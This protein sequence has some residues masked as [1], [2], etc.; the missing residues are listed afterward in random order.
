MRTTLRFSTLIIILLFTMFT[1]TSMAN[2]PKFKTPDFAYPQ[3]V[4]KDAQAL[5]KKSEAMPASLDADITRTRA[6]IELCV[7]QQ[8]I[9]FDTTFTQ[10]AFIEAQLANS[11]L[12]DVGRALL[13]AYEAKLFTDIYRRNSWK[14]N[15]VDAP[16]QPYPADVSEWS[17]LQF[18]THISELLEKA[19]SYAG[20]TPLSD[21]SAV[22]EASPEGLL[23]IPTLADFVRKLTYDTY[24]SF[25]YSD[26]SFS[27]KAKSV[28]ADAI[29][30][31]AADSAPWFYWSVEQFGGPRGTAP[32]YER[33]SEL[34]SQH[35]SA[36]AARYVLQQM[37]RHY[38]PTNIS[39]EAN[40]L[41]IRQKERERR[42][43]FLI[44][45]I[46]NS[47]KA[48]PKWYGN[49]SLK[50]SLN[51]LTQPEASFS[52]PSKAGVGEKTAIDITYA[53]AKKVQLGIYSL[54]AGTTRTDAKAI[55]R[56]MPKVFSAELTP[57]DT[58]GK[59]TEY[60]S[61]DKPGL[62]AVIISINGTT[63][64]GYVRNLLVTPL[65]GFVVNG[66]P[67]SA[68]IVGDYTLG[69]PLKGTQASLVTNN[70]RSNTNT[71]PRRLG[72]T[73]SDGVLVFDTPKSENR[74]ISRYISLSYQGVTYDLNKKLDV[75]PYAPVEESDSYD[76]Q[77]MTDR[78]I[79]HPGDSIS[80]AAVLGMKKK[81][82]TEGTVLSGKDVTVKLFDANYKLVDTISV[83]T[84]SNGRVYGTFATK[85]GGLTGDYT[86]QVVNKD[87]SRTTT[88]MVSDFKAPTIEAEIKSVR[89]D[90]PAPGAV[91][92][93]GVAKTY[94]GM[95]VAGADVAV[96]L[97]GASRWR[98]FRPQTTLTTMNVTTTAD[99][100]FSVVFPAD[101]LA[102]PFNNGIP[103]TDFVAQFTVTS[104]TAETAETSKSFTTGKP[105]SLDIITPSLANS[106]KP[107]DM[108]IRAYDANGN[109]KP[110]A[111][112][113]QLCDDAKTPGLPSGTVTA[114]TPVKLDFS[115]L[116]SG[117]YFFMA[118][119]V[120]TTLAD[121]APKDEIRLYSLHRN[122]LPASVKGFILPESKTKVKNG[123]AEVL[124]GTNADRLYL[125]TITAKKD[126]LD[127][128]RLHELRKGFSKVKVKVDKDVSKAQL[129][130]AAIL[131]GEV[132]NQTVT[133]EADKAETTEIIAESF[134]D[135][136]VPGRGETW[137][138]RL[139]KG[140]KT[141]TDAAMV[142]TM[143][144]HALDALTDGDWP[145]IGFKFWQPNSRM[146]LSSPSFYTISGNVSVR[147]NY[148]EEK[149]I[150]WP[151]F[152]FADGPR[153]LYI[154]GSRMML[155]SAATNSAVEDY[156]EEDVECEATGAIEEAYAA[157]EAG[158]EVP[159]PNYCTIDQSKSGPKMLDVEYREAEVLQA[160]WKPALVA[161]K[162]GNIDIVFTVPNA[163]TTWRFKAFAWD[164]KLN[165]ADYIESALANK[166]VMV[167]ANLPR[168]LRQGDTATILA[169]VFNNS[170]ETSAVTTT[171]EIF[172]I[173]SGKTVST[174]SFT[175]TIAPLAS[176]IVK[177]DATAP[178][179]AA[180]I[181][182]RVRAVAGSFAD[183]E[184][185]AI[186]VLASATTVIESTEFYL[187]PDDSKPFEL[188]V[189]GKDSELTLQ[190]CQ[191]P[192]WTIVRAMRGIA[193][194]ESLTATGTVS[195]LFSAL[196]AKHITD[197]NPAIA[198]AIRRWNGNPSDRALTSM[199]ER[200]ETLKKLLLD[201]T[202]WVQT[203][204]SNT[205]RME[206]LAS[207]LEPGQSAKAIADARTALAKFQNA[208]GG[209]CWGGWSHESSVWSTEIV[210]TTLGIANSLGMLGSDYDSL[211]EPAFEYLQKEAAKPR[212]P[213]TDEDLA[214]IATFFPGYKQTVGGSRIIR[215]TVAAIARNWKSDNT[216]AKAYDVL[217]LAGNG[218][219][220]EAA[221]VLESIRQ[222]GVVRP[223]MGLCFPNVSDT[224]SYATI[225]QAFAKMDASKTEIDAMRQWLTVQAQ[226]LD[227]IGA[228]NPDYIIA[229]VMMTGSDWTSVPVAQNVTVNG[230][231]LQIDDIES[232]TGYF[233]QTIDA[234]G[235]VTITVRPNGVTPSYGSVI[236][237]SRRPM[238]AVKARPGRDLSIE[239]RCL[240]ERDGQWVETDRFTLGERVRV[241]LTVKAK[242]NLEYV[243]IDDERPAAFAPV[244]QLPGYVW[245]GGLGFY[246]ENLD[247]ST[248]L[249]ISYLP[250]GTYHLSYD[251]T[252]AAAGT[253]IS[254]IATLQSQ[255]APELT[256]HSAGSPITVE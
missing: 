227:D 203:A 83:T 103:Y 175:D 239:K 173:E 236:A 235:K 222:F 251:M 82:K 210:L 89:R 245:D 25:I 16:L 114:G 9:D 7:A 47:L 125:Y 131:D 27:D 243:S 208:D 5:L 147:F 128:V 241:Q 224:R 67:K 137:R 172:D 189:N 182:Y 161:D 107:F 79:Y 249:F 65:Y 98:W 231:P 61:I 100:T 14:Y 52:M 180:A 242:R 199:L 174:Q 68:V 19:A 250:Q 201:Q 206:A 33:L 42:A 73:D 49:N 211:L 66:G 29:K 252:A 40:D 20:G 215:N 152:I 23:Y 171:V 209:F 28:C 188:T 234:T 238:K 69:S 240:V 184:Q 214:L 96:T 18:R 102:K 162:D 223:G 75:N 190:Y 221:K 194:T 123:A 44:A 198:D 93:E 117:D 155:K 122:T 37:C 160:F 70:Y 2:G 254:G 256:A 59:A 116:T 183:G 205:A 12:T 32:E 3:T 143:Y 106:D 192:I 48:F 124:I 193:S 195:H 39:Y 141:I 87:R 168:F 92:L 78:A 186:P 187:N 4:I 94:S 34:Y 218:R 200:N 101:I 26:N 77:I 166:P 225:I 151:E 127:A 30:T 170:D 119:P 46:S 64:G 202:P 153:P 15:R 133:L 136:L 111:V 140:G 179:S 76:I 156:K 253:F 81:G 24:S 185:A 212:M 105:Y 142:A 132:Y 230:T 41:E 113:W 163:N 167:Q 11:K 126:T 220:A 1:N 217:I 80:W 129:I 10:P 60:F 74:Y 237:I 45:E 104:L 51:K 8:A 56:R 135:K 196:A 204:K 58:R 177:I 85:K 120:D 55:A 108:T 165:A 118:E 71:T 159:R 72:K 255:Y 207:L 158:S 229:A 228:Y 97:L 233:A 121:A 145:F 144:N 164:K 84:D 139:A 86:I 176:A 246:R 63:D 115:N 244:D 109:E 21:L 62:Y 157:D 90:V 154:R 50:N 54:P 213:E 17:G 150:I 53:F 138:F 219:R 146:T 38:T 6:V 31:S 95:P 130:V 178:V 112:K 148:L 248:R 226:A 36:E 134:R 110:L 197:T 169:T 191:N 13:T 88:I 35:S 181:G 43:D 99:G 232:A 57:T 216:T 149:D 247:A 91:T 22:I